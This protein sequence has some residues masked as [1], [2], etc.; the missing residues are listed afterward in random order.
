MDSSPLTMHIDGTDANKDNMF[1]YDET[2]QHNKVF[3][4]IS[5]S[6]QVL[7]FI[8]FNVSTQ[9]WKTRLDKL[10]LINF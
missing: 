4:T 5:S 8:F 3:V 9:E 1:F 7:L 6:L 10:Q 2:D